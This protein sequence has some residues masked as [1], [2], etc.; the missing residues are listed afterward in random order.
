VSGFEAWPCYDVLLLGVDGSYIR[1]NAIR[2]QFADKVVCLALCW[3]LAL[4][5]LRALII[6]ITAYDFA[7]YLFR[8]LEAL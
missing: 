2:Y 1:F 6:N 4:G 3:A 8:A 7:K 5:R